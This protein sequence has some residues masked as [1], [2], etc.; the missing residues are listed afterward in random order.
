M[1]WGVSDGAGSSLGS[2]MGGLSD[3]G[4]QIPERGNPADV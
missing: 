1:Q 4:E 2:Y 3:A